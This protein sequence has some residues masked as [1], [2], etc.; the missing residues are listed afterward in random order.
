MT[1][2]SSFG[3]LLAGSII[4]ALLADL[5][6]LPALIL[7]LKPFGPEFPVEVADSFGPLQPTLQ[8]AD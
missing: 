8:P 5:L 7:W 2:L 3:V 6:L 4:T 1:V